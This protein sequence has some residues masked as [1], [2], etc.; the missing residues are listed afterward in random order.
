[1]LIYHSIIKCCLELMHLRSS[2]L[3]LVIIIDGLR[4]IDDHLCAT[5]QYLK[6]ILN[7]WVK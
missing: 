1:M 6:F 3:L 5:R 2:I 4:V 7:G